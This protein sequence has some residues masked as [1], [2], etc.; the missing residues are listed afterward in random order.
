[1]RSIENRRSVRKYKKKDIPD[2][3]V[4][5]LLES[6]RLAP[7][8]SNTQ[9]WRFIIVRDPDIKKKIVEAD[10]NQRWM[11]SAPVFLVCVADL[12][13]RI[14]NTDDIYVDED[15]PLPELK[16]IIRDTA[17]AIENILLEA[18][19]LGLGACWT[20]WFN[21][22]DM[23]ECLGIPTDKYVCGV[24]T[25]GYSDEHGAPQKRKSLDSLVMYDKWKE[26]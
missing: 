26:I 16:L 2:E 3:T 25:V 13:C 15:S 24:V 10:H 22:K 11:L 18:E 1:M 5:A 6:G 17:I 20:A 9:P 23:R 12:C 7:S 19:E 8:G 21:Q 4:M 14:S